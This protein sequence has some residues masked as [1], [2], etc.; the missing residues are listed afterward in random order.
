MKEFTI[1]WLTGVDSMHN[2]NTCMCDELDEAIDAFADEAIEA[3]EQ[4]IEDFED[5]DFLECEGI[6]FNSDDF[7]DEEIGR[8]IV[9]SEGGY[10]FMPKV[11]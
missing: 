3:M 10:D 9:T 8:L 6:I 5:V 7:D 2:I 11:M 4:E 1:E